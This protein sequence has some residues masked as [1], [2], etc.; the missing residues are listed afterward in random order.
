M[1]SGQRAVVSLDILPHLE[2]E[3]KERQRAA[4]EQ[5]G[6][7]QEKGSQRI[8]TP[9]LPQRSDDRA[10]KLTGTNRQYVSDAKKLQAEASIRSAHRE[11][12]RTTEQA[13]RQR[14]RRAA[15]STRMKVSMVQRGASMVM[16]IPADGLSAEF[17]KRYAM[18][19]RGWRWGVFYGNVMQ[20]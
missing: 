10:A 13:Q 18:G 6:R 8:G 16:S 4:G 12:I 19:G 17:R 7:G 1:S 2:A 3:A 9:I 14:R 15:I 5:H 20:W 11:R